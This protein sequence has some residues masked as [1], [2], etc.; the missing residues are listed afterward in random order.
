[1]L[2]LWAIWWFTAV[3]EGFET[4]A[5]AFLVLVGKTSAGVIYYADVDVPFTPKWQASSL[6]ATGS[7]GVAYGQLYTITGTSSVPK[8]SS[9]D[10]NS[11]TAT[12]GPAL[13]QIY[14]DDGGTIGGID[15]AGSVYYGSAKNTNTLMKWVTFSGSNS[16]GVGTDGS[17]YFNANPGSGTWT[18]TNAGT[19]WKQV[20]L[21]G[22][23]VC[24]I[25]TAGNI[26]YAENNITTAATVWKTNSGPI[27]CPTFS[28]ISVTGKRLIGVGTDSNIYYTDDVTSSRI[29]RTIS[30]KIYNNMGVPLT[31]AAPTFTTIEMMYPD[32][33]AR[34]KRFIDVGVK[35]CNLSETLIGNYC[36][37]PCPN[38]KEGLG[39][40]CPYLRQN[41]PAKATCPAGTTLINNTCFNPCSAQTTTQGGSTFPNYT[42]DP[43]NNQQCLGATLDKLKTEPSTAFTPASYKP[44]DANNGALEGRYVRIRPTQSNSNNKLCLQ[45]VTVMGYKI[46]KSGNRE[47]NLVN[48]SSSG[49]AFST[50]GLCMTGPIVGGCQFKSGTTFDKDTDGGQTNRTAKTYW[51][52]DL[53]SLNFIKSVSITGCSNT[54]SGTSSGTSDNTMQQMAGTRLE[55]LTGN[56]NTTVPL[57]QRILGPNTTQTVTFNFGAGNSQID[58]PPSNTCYDLCPMVAGVQSVPQRNGACVVDVRTINN[59]SI[60]TPQIIRSKVVLPPGNITNESGKIINTRWIA[61]PT[62]LTQYITCSGFAGSSLVPINTTIGGFQYS[63]KNS[64]TQQVF[65]NV[66]GYICVK[67]ES[68]NVSMCPSYTSSNNGDR[69][70]LLVYKYDPTT[71]SCFLPRNLNRLWSCNTMCNNQWASNIGANNISCDIPGNIDTYTYCCTGRISVPGR[72]GEQRCWTNT[73][74]FNQNIE[75]IYSTNSSYNYALPSIPGH[76]VRL[77]LRMPAKIGCFDSNGDNTPG[78][79]EYN[80]ACASCLSKHD[81]FYGAGLLTPEIQTDEKYGIYRGQA[82]AYTRNSLGNKIATPIPSAFADDYIEPPS[83]NNPSTTPSNTTAVIDEVYGPKGLPPDPPPL[84]ESQKARTTL[85]QQITDGIQQAS[86]YLSSLSQFKP[87]G[88]P[89]VKYTHDTGAFDRRLNIADVGSVYPSGICVG[90]CSADF[91]K[92]L[93][94]QMHINSELGKYILW[95][96]ACESITTVTIMQDKIPAEYIPEIGSQCSANTSYNSVD[97]LCYSQCNT[98]QIDNGASCTYKTISRPYVSPTYSCTNPSLTLDG[99]VCLY[100]C[101]PGTIENGT[102]C[103]PVAVVLPNLPTIM[104]FQIINCNKTPG[105]KK[106]GKDINK[107]LCESKDFAYLLLSPPCNDDGPTCAFKDPN[108]TNPNISYSYVGPEDIICHA[109]SS[110]ST[111][112]VCQDASEY[113]SGGDTATNTTTATKEQINSQLT[114]DNLSAAYIDLSNNLTILQTS[115]SVA[116]TSSVRLANMQATLEGIYNVLCGSNKPTIASCPTLE[117]QIAALRSSINSGSATLANIINPYEI[118]MTSRT[119]LVAEMKNLA[120]SIPK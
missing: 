69:S 96:A 36:Y 75:G 53:G 58:A 20:V 116:Q 76:L 95:G 64:S 73:T 41:I 34:R 102:Y 13:K 104:G 98:L 87:N 12:T 44:C 103:D 3:K 84:T 120:C 22:A 6:T 43:A 1:M 100:G 55:I 50:D 78:V 62:D 65:P 80:N 81:T 7:I 57:V 86:S 63:Y 117:S 42:E 37:Q 67:K 119:N 61:D 79:F 47:T 110:G 82:V 26:S 11:S 107:W 27:A 45:N 21:S 111:V 8:M 112:Y 18:K 92:T 88:I 60:T 56:N 101:K 115:G 5:P 93:P 24:A 19:T 66:A 48:L 33:S 54:S 74:V 25:N 30:T 15:D 2:A 51:E 71:M 114:C 109:D 31:S 99:S 17:L 105:G 39:N 29:W 106:S 9:Y 52:V 77:P 113:L 40:M 23:L 49:T 14:V 89:T 91:S 4:T 46:D 85:V 83:R 72:G 10:A 97:N 28:Y 70:D 94:V 35:T 32:P 108:V 90:K 38:G 59:R 68:I 118:G 16:Y